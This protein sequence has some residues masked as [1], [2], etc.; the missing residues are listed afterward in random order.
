V[1]PFA[2]LAAH[3]L[4]NSAP[5]IQRRTG[6]L[7]AAYALLVLAASPFI[8]WEV[9]V[10]SDR[11]LVQSF[12]KAA[13]AGAQ[14]QYLTHPAFSSA[15]YTRGT[16]RHEEGTAGLLP[17]APSHATYVV[18]DNHDLQRLA[19]PAAIVL[20]AGQKRSLVELK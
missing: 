19:I 16:L 20:Y 5:R 4:E 3:W 1:P 8:V 17:S 12:E 11:A 13:P 18:M 6:L 10:N 2:V 14:L 15:F 9:G 7:L